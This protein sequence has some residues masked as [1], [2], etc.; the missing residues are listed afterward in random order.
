MR[1]LPLLLL[2][3]AAPLQAQS[4]DCDG[5]FTPLAVPAGFCVRPFAE[6]VGP[7]RQLVVHPTGVVIA[8]TKLP[9][10]L[11]SLADTSGDGIADVVTRFGPGEGGTGVTWSGGW[12]YF[13][14]DVG[15]YRIP[16]PAAARAP[17]GEGEWIAQGLPAAGSSGWAHTM[18]GIAVGADGAVYVSI[19][20]A[21][22]N[23]Q[24]SPEIMPQEGLWPCPE[25]STRAGIWRFTPPPKAGGAWVGSRHATG[26]RNAMALAH[27]PATGTLWAASHGRDFLNR[28]W[29]WSAEESANQ[30]AE[31][32]LRVTRGADFGW[33]YCMGRWRDSATTL[34]VAPEYDKQEGGAACDRRSQPAAGYPGH[35]SPMAIAP[36]TAALPTAWR[37]GLFLAFHGSRTRAPLPEAG[38]MVLFQ[39]FNAAGMPAGEHRIFLRTTDKPGSLRPAGVAI[40]PNGVVYVADDD[41]AR[42]I[43]I[44]PR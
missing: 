37:N 2:L 28:A 39:P 26:L 30:P 1:R 6:K 25:L 34:M 19:G 13:A 24:P 41:H 23:C 4:R 43:R 12:V 11:V 15:I 9:P 22:D 5:F 31:L 44:E 29:G 8:A 42:I 17:T 40:A 35:W 33:P 27:D 16:W 32:L 14:A 10:G 7:V 36:A 21:T 20:S 38:H 3:I 18:K